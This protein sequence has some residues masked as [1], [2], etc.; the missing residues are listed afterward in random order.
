MQLS[1][2][3]CGPG[4]CAFC[5]RC[6]GS[7]GGDGERR[8]LIG[9]AARDEAYVG[10]N[11]RPP[12]TDQRAPSGAALPSMH[13]RMPRNE[14]L[15]RTWGTTKTW[16]PRL[17]R[18]ARPAQEAERLA[19]ESDNRRDSAHL[20]S[21]S[22]HFFESAAVDVVCVCL[23]PRVFPRSLACVCVCVFAWGISSRIASAR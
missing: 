6:D 21:T 20:A 15:A 11:G 9:R 18:E 17:Q 1:C 14:E 7:C 2:Y 3:R 4:L 13:S 10:P 22:I 12:S 8:W 5:S 23:A 19:L 16:M